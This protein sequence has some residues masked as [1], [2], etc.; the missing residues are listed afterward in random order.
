L[1]GR[2]SNLGIPIATLLASAG[3]GG[4]ALA[5]GAQDT[6]KTLFGTLNLLTDKP[7]RVGDRI[8]FETYDGVVEDI[9]LRTSKIR[10]LNGNQ[11]SLPNDQLAGNDIEN[12]GRRRYIRRVGQIH[13][14]LDTV[15]EK[16]QQAVAIIRE[17]LEDHEGMDL[18]YPP[19]VYLDEF[20]SDAFSIQFYYWYSPP[21]FWKFKAFGDKLNFSIFRRFEAAGIQFSLPFR[22]SLWKHD[23]VQG[24]LEVNLQRNG[25]QA[26][27]RT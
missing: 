8:I 24:P 19:R 6:L 18:S 14:P 7:F 27:S 3:I 20:G 15:C 17:E 9:G 1:L 11:V 5:L 10:L 12:V 16:V 4:L 21:D 23:D 25:I 2:L 22:H 13:I 26:V